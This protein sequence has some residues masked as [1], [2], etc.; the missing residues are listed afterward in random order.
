[1]FWPAVSRIREAA[2]GGGGDSWFFMWNAWYI[3]ENIFSPG[4]FTTDHI[5]FPAGARLYFQTFSWPN[6]ILVELLNGLTGSMIFSYNLVLLSTFVVAG[7]SAFLLVRYLFQDVRVALIAGLIFAFAPYRM[8]RALGQMNLLSVH[9]LPLYALFLFKTVDETGW[10][11]PLLAALFGSLTF[12][13]SYIIGLYTAIF[14][15]I[16]AIYISFRHLGGE[17]VVEKATVYRILAVALTALIFVSP[18][19]SPL[20]TGLS[21]DGRADVEVKSVEAMDY[22]L[23]GVFQSTYSAASWFPSQDYL[24]L[25]RAAFLGFAVIAFSATSLFADYRY[26]GFWLSSTSLF[27]L[28]SLGTDTLIGEIVFSLPVFSF[29][30]NSNRLSVMV[31]FSLLLPASY[32][33]ALLMDRLDDIYLKDVA[34]AALILLVALEFSMYPY[35]SKEPFIEDSTHGFYEDLSS[36]DF[37]GSILDIPYRQDSLRKNMYWQTVHNRKIVG[38]EPSRDLGGGFDYSQRP[39]LDDLRRLNYDRFANDSADL[40]NFL[41]ENDVHYIIVHRRYAEGWRDMELGTRFDRVFE[42][43]DIFVFEV[44]QV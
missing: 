1:M 36:R 42:S 34:L 26:K 15:L 9:W 32:G 10:K 43:E 41:Q 6:T 22:I 8:A 11:N 44:G 5:M 17:E 16:Y 12:L 37:N 3:G 31:F 19:L 20:L 13:S 23:P 21:Y 4:F 38:G 30:R 2:I 40:A 24:S 14:S 29:I 27:F 25:K 35:P 33:I 28:L 39:A 18:L 7:L